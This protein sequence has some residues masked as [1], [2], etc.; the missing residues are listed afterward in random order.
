[1]E[2]RNEALVMVEVSLQL[3]CACHHFLC[4]G[5]WCFVAELCCSAGKYTDDDV[6]ASIA[7]GVEMF[8]RWLV[9]G[10]GGGPSGATL[11]FP[12]KGLLASMCMDIMLHVL[13][14]FYTYRTAN[15]YIDGVLS[16]LHLHCVE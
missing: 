5:R 15:V 6:S 3:L 4:A 10:A 9:Y 11:N 13:I 8:R 7:T 14:L 12:W 2:E 16:V 1:M